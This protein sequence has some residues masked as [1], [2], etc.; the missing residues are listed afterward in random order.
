MIYDICSFNNELDML[1]LR[2]KILNDHV[3]KFIIVEANTTFS[4]VEKPLNYLNNRERF[5]EYEDKILY[6]TVPDSPTSFED[7]KC[8]QEI[9][10]MALD[11]DNVTR[12]H[13]C[14]LVEFYQKEYIKKVL[15]GVLE[16]DDICYVCDLDEIWNYDLNFEVGDDIHKPKINNCYIDYLNLKTNENWTFFT[17][18]IVTKYK[19]IKNECLNHLRTLRKMQDR[20][21]Y[22][23][24]GGWH[25]NA[26]GG[27]DKKIEDFQHPV[28]HKDYM[29]KRKHGA[30]VDEAGL[31]EYILE[32]REELKEKGLF[33]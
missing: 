28:Y 10:Q 25:F 16:D 18:P 1:D 7:D 6:Y 20:Y 19:N 23:E 9:L 3:D 30:R 12:E 33:L 5:K 17:G 15:G 2:L 29:E 32:H 13:I 24:D 22:H 11:S 4:G 14:W 8:D 31:P 27:S 26:L 21:T